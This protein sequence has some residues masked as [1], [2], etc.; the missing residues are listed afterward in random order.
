MTAIPR[1]LGESP[2]YINDANTRET[3]MASGGDSSIFP[4]AASDPE[5]RM[6]IERA[7][8]TFPDFLRELDDDS[9][10]LLPVV[11]TALVKAY[12]ADPDERDHGEHLWVAVNEWTPDSVVGEVL[13]QPTHV[14]IVSQGEDV[15]IATEQ[16]SD[17]LYVADGVARGAY[18]VRL[19][20]Q[21]MTSQ[22]RREH[23]AGYPY[24]FE[25]G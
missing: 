17:W 15:R 19:L 25:R 24:S 7:R 18:T 3:V 16:L 5:M 22:E 12:F 6:A 20:R 8:Q 1:G 23:D 4:I 2:A 11:E 10:R 14:K 21:R 9:K 13:S